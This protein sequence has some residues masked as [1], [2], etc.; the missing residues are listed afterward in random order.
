MRSP[1]THA[2]LK[3]FEKSIQLGILN[4]LQSC[5]PE[6]PD[7]F[8]FPRV[9]R[10][11]LGLYKSGTLQELD[12]AQINANAYTSEGRTALYWACCRS[13]TEAL[14]YLLRIRPNQNTLDEALM[15]ACARM[16]EI[17]VQLLLSHGAKPNSRSREGQTPL[18]HLF[19]ACQ[20]PLSE[21]CEDHDITRLLLYHG[22]DI[23]HHDPRGRNYLCYAAM[24]G[25][26]KSMDLILAAGCSIDHQDR[27]GWTPLFYAVMGLLQASIAIL[28]EL[29]AS[30][31]FKDIRGRTL[32]HYVAR[33][34]SVEVVTT[35]L[36]SDRFELSPDAKD[37]QGMTAS[38]YLDAGSEG[39]DDGKRPQDWEFPS[40][41]HQ[42]LAKLRTSRG[43]D[44]A[45]LHSD[46]WNSAYIADQNGPEI[47]R[48]QGRSNQ[49]S[50]NSEA[51]TIIDVAEDEYVALSNVIRRPD[52]RRVGKN[53]VPGTLLKTD[54][55]DEKGKS[56]RVPRE[57][58]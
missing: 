18:H 33:Y 32:L 57:E 22:L 51:T 36:N 46:T 9:T 42:L 23:Q 41:F 39:Y 25:S 48:S 20:Q 14:G 40:L 27:S 44:S 21:R 50:F 47:L 1:Q 35:L 53:I 7:H 49:P 26:L 4:Q 19:G 10:V 6:M 15:V 8:N 24:T 17:C 56:P 3:I 54:A 29:G 13:D 12:S 5:F 45:A 58:T 11:I 37:D 2:G 55:T 31:E 38:D 30:T 52:S 16:S 34:P 43:H 28:L